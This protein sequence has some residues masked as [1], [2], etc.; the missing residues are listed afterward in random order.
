[1]H[2]RNLTLL[3]L[4]LL[5]GLTSFATAQ[6]QIKLDRLI[7]SVESNSLLAG[8]TLSE[9]LPKLPGVNLNE[10]NELVINGKGGVLI[11]I[12]GKG[13]YVSKEQ[14]A[15]FLNNIVAESIDKI[16]IISNP[17]VK[18]DSNGGAVINI[19]TKKDKMTSDVHESMGQQLSQSRGYLV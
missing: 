9:L 5:I 12:D 18:Y 16:E 13:Q 7:I 3:L 17:S 4:I 6:P 2:N 11:L 1:M 10:K 8:N 15:S 19:I 14:Q